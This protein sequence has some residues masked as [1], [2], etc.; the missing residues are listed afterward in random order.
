MLSGLILFPILTIYILGNAVGNFFTE[1]I[2]NKI[3]VGYVIEDDGVIG[4]GFRGFLQSDEI[5]ARLELM[6]YDEIEMARQATD[7]GQ[8]NGIIVLPKNLSSN[9]EIGQNTA[10]ELYGKKNIEFIESLVQGFISTYN[11]VNTVN[12]LGGE[13]IFPERMEVIQRIYYG[14][15]GKTPDLIDYYSILTLLQILILGGIFGVMI[16]NGDSSSDLRIRLHT[17][18][19]S[20]RNIVV[21]QIIG[22]VIYLFITSIFLVLFTKYVYNANWDGNPLIIAATMLAFSALVVGIGIL[23]GLIVRNNSSA[24]MVI[25]LLMIIYGTVSGS[26]S[27]V[28][29]IEALSI[30]TPNVH[31]KMLLFGTIYDYSNSIMIEATL[32]LTVFLLIVYGAITYLLGRDTYDHI[33]SSN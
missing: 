21:G 23:V 6:E 25:L 33:Q 19:I 31:A 28:S 17:L 30:V 1:D 26:V 8:V 7:Q 2:T 24:I 4:N 3:P 10:I 22:N 13:A 16:V 29:T 32:W 9:I 27:P 11:T 14:E 15:E 12:Y 20:R 18:P 5:T